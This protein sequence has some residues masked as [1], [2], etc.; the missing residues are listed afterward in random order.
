MKQYKTVTLS[1]W[2]HT[3]SFKLL[4]K[5]VNEWMSSE[6]SASSWSR[7][8]E[9]YI[10]KQTEELDKVLSI[11]FYAEVTKRNRENNELESLKIIQSATER[12]LKE[13]TLHSWVLCSLG[14]FT[15]QKKS[16]AELHRRHP[17]SPS[18]KTTR[19]VS[20]NH[21]G[22][23]GLPSS[24]QATRIELWC[25]KETIFVLTSELLICLLCLNEFS[26][27]NIVL[28]NK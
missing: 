28:H 17:Q 21:R 10:L 5:T 1:L 14:S 16:N 4:N 12:Y 7:Q 13:K 25:M 6:A 2:I 19:S 9:K 23:E 18:P 8:F 24:I 20:L 22:K 3:K 27:H 11:K 15:T 26:S